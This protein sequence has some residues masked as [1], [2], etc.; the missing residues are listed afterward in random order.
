MQNVLTSLHPGIQKVSMTNT[1]PATTLGPNVRGSLTIA[2]DDLEAAVLAN[3][4]TVDQAHNVWAFLSD[5]S[6]FTSPTTEARSSSL[7]R[8][9]GC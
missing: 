8:W 4:L 5:R 2:A 9:A 1:E 6:A 7:P 3:L